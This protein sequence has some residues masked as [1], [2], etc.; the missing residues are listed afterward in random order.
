[1]TTI[2]ITKE[3]TKAIVAVLKKRFPN[4]TVEETVDLSFDIME[5]IAKENK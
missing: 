1:M 5:A 2:Y 3:V 4:L